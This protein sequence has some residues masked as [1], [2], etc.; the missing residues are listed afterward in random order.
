MYVFKNIREDAEEAFKII[1]N[2]KI[3][4]KTPLI[5][6]SLVIKKISEDLNIPKDY[7]RIIVKE[8]E[9]RQNKLKIINFSKYNSRHKYNFNDLINEDIKR[10]KYVYIN[11][12]SEE[13]NEFIANQLKYDNLIKKLSL[14]RL[15][16]R[17]GFPEENINKIMLLANAINIKNGKLIESNKNT[18]I[19]IKSEI[20]EKLL[21]YLN[22]IKNEN[23]FNKNSS[24]IINN[25]I[26]NDNIF[27]KI[28]KKRL[29]IY[30]SNNKLYLTQKGIIK[31]INI[32]SNLLKTH[33][34][35]ILSIDQENFFKWVTQE[36]LNNDIY[37]LYNPEKKEKSW[38]NII[39]HTKINNK[40]INI[41]EIP[42]YKEII[43][44]FEKNKLNDKLKDR[45]PDKLLR[46]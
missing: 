17:S 41:N 30:I 7:T 15:L 24:K 8:L 1:E 5:P 34:Y 2:I 19:L 40:L 46:N 32:N 37:K 43:S 21:D 18:S 23:D 22:S 28:D 11:L 31:F 10:I 27:K 39:N 45:K 12:D 36:V 35:Y 3:N 38:H 26:Y 14:I 44:E 25:K 33:K 6:Y 13:V 4:N 42:V 29:S 20:R 16:K 9:H